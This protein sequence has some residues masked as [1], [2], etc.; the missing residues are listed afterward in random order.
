MQFADIVQGRRSVKKFDPK[1][2]ITDAE[3]KTI[4]GLVEQSPSSFN[5]QHWRFVVVRDAAGKAAMRKASFNQEQVETAS[6]TIV[7]AAKLAA[8]EDAAKIYADTPPAVRDS[9]VPMIAGYYADHPQLRRDEAIRSASLAAMT[10]MYAAYDQGYASCPMIGF[11]PKA[12]SELVRLDAGHFPVML[13][14]IGKQVGQMRPRASRLPIREVV[15]LETM[16][17]A[18]L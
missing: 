11:D 13:V 7:V 18:G 2:A 16:D 14:V 9:M 10:L 4:F 3:L 12:V 17:G 5:L 6:A 1:H 8:H 15:R